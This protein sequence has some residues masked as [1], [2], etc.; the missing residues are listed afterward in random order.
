MRLYDVEMIS[1]SMGIEETGREGN[2][3]FSDQV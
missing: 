1:Q 2:F 3:N